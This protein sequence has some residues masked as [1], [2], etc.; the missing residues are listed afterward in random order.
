M[1]EIVRDGDHQV[2]ERCE[3]KDEAE[4]RA[5]YLSQNPYTG[6][7][8]REARPTTKEKLRLVSNRAMYLQRALQDMS[9]KVDKFGHRLGE[10]SLT[11]QSIAQELDTLLSSSGQ[12]AD[13]SGR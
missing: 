9:G 5:R 13:F 3:T 2:V 4:K 11:A 8:A 7:S 1:Y 12:D 10:L 6:F